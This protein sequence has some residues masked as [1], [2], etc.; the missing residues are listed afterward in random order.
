MA[1]VRVKTSV[2]C[3]DIGRRITVQA[4]EF[5]KVCMDNGVYDFDTAYMYFL[6]QRPI[7]GVE[8]D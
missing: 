1:T 2:G 5:V 7:H 3:S 8:K 4:K 6:P